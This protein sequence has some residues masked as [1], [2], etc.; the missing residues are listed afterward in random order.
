MCALTWAVTRWQHP[1]VDTRLVQL[2]LEVDELVSQPAV[3]R[4]GSTF[5]FITGG[6]LAVRKLDQ[7][8]IKQLAG[9]EG[10]SSPFFSPD[11]KFIAFF[12]NRKLQRVAID[13][14]SPTTICEASGSG[15]EP[16]L[17]VA[18]SWLPSATQAGCYSV[19]CFGWPASSVRDYGWRQA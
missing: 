12:A 9:T 4:D 19:E 2:D 6:R 18:R 13:G 8:Q 15:A 1:L 5:A 10:A 7:N 14:G 3:S 17:T 11:G 16:G